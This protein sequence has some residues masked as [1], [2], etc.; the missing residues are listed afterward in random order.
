[1]K[2]KSRFSVVA[3]AVALLMLLTAC[4][5]RLNTT[6]ALEEG[7][8]GTRTISFTVA[9]DA[10]TR[11]RITGGFEAADA[12]IVKHL[13]EGLEFSGL[14]MGEAEVTG[15]FTLSFTDMDDYKSKVTAILEA[16]GLDGDPEITFFSADGSFKKGFEFE[17]S[18]SSSDLLAWVPDALVVEGVIAEDDR[19]NVIDG[20]DPSTVTYGGETYTSDYGGSIF[21][22]QTQD[23]GFDNVYLTIAD[24]DDGSFGA[25]VVLERYSKPTEPIKKI[26]DEFL[27]KFSGMTIDSDTDTSTNNYQRSLSFDAISA[28]D[29][30]LK[31]DDVFGEGA[32]SFEVGTGGE[33]G[34]AKLQRTYRGT[35]DPVELC[36]SYCGLEVHMIAPEGYTSGGG[37][38]TDYAYGTSFEFA[39]DKD[40]VFDSLDFAVNVSM[41]REWTLDV[42]VVL[43]STE[44]ADF[45]D[46]VEAALAE[47]G[48]SMKISDADGKRTYSFSF[49]PKDESAYAWSVR[50]RTLEGVEKEVTDGDYEVQLELDP[51]DFVGGAQISQ[52]TGSVELGTMQKWANVSDY[53]W[54]RDGD[55]YTY[56]VSDASSLWFEGYA[57]GP[58][59]GKLIGMIIAAVVVIALIA[60]AIIFR[61]KIAKLFSKGP[62]PAP[63]PG[64]AGAAGVAGPAGA[65]GAQPYSVQSGAP[66]GP[67]APGQGAELG[68]QPEAPQF[69]A[70]HSAE[71]STF[72]GAQPGIAPGVP[73]GP[74]AQA[75][76]GV[77]APS[78][79]APGDSASGGAASGEFREYDLT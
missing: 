30:V 33:N 73:A 60:L 18:F 74:G 26:D 17:E 72:A 49:T 61:K 21:I 22:D 78:A 11:D 8:A 3:L 25:V 12:A 41:S 14:T 69:S 55:T 5:A 27:G 43:D 23:Q 29:L 9:N 24:N 67:G 47:N 44:Y 76:P 54:T 50:V 46:Q 28:E 1:M 36:S 56:S 42:D 48:G 71:A 77:P 79:P 4:G 51:Y 58:T 19:S 16:G 37:D 7:G 32:T 68:V 70:A 10:D 34:E 31:L 53:L 15:N 66:V 75:G 62:K 39:F 35:A 40:I 20:E 38:N 52:V 57:S 65:Y 64:A 2:T 63:Y 45:L 13:P 59:M 6:V